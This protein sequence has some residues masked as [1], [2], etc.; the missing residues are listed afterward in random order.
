MP[1]SPEG[2]IARLSRRDFLHLSGL[3]LTVLV[4]E[5]CSGEVTDTG[6][7]KIGSPTPEF[8]PTAA[9]TVIPTFTPRI[10]TPTPEVPKYIV[11]GFEKLEDIADKFPNFNTTNPDDPYYPW[12]F[13]NIEELFD[14]YFIPPGVEL[15]VP[16]DKIEPPTL[17]EIDLSPEN[18]KYLLAEHKTSLRDSSE[19]R[20]WNIKLGAKNLNGQFILPYRLFSIK[21]AI[22]PIDEKHG[23]LMGKGYQDAHEVDMMGGGICQVPSTVFKTV[24]EAGLFVPK[25]ARVAHTFYW[26]N[27]GPFDATISDTFD[28]AFRN[29]CNFPMQI[30]TFI[31]GNDLKVNIWSPQPLP[32]REIK[33]EVVFN[34][35]IDE[36]KW[37]D[38][39][40]HSQ[41][42]QA[43][44]DQYG[45]TRVVQYDSQYLPYSQKIVIN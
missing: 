3:F 17:P 32:Y 23:F 41:V 44:I 10:E 16:N 37:G 18:F 43:V 14:P 42:Q 25:S 4:L 39:K 27:Y 20:R 12:Y 6:R 2:R 8:S 1:Y 36:K 26:D 45:R 34:D 7:K 40:R 19:G 33:V 5:A 22:G 13:W 15:I 24:L 11:K 28:L 21:K 30:R 35:K 31:E 9:P 38:D 29:L